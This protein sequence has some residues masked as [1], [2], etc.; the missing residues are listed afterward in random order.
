[1]TARTKDRAAPREA[2]QEQKKLTHPGNLIGVSVSLS[3]APRAPT[4]MLLWTGIGSHDPSTLDEAPGKGA[5]EFARPPEKLIDE[6]TFPGNP[7]I[8]G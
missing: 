5:F 8:I 2:D 7:R 1:M 3:R 6:L 4:L